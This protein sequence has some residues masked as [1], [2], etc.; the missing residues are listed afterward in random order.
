[1]NEAS[2]AMR[3][4]QNIELRCGNQNFCLAQDVRLVYCCLNKNLTGSPE[5]SPALLTDFSVFFTYNYTFTTL[6]TNTCCLTNNETCGFQ[7]NAKRN[8]L[9]IK[10]CFFELACYE[11]MCFD[12]GSFQRDRKSKFLYT[13]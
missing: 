2:S 7:N 11:R 5:R 3:A 10:Y 9:S 4:S 13:L 12:V 1:M 6:N 8:K